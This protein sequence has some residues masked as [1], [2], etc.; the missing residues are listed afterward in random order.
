MT[1]TFVASIQVTLVAAAP[2]NVASAALVRHLDGAIVLDRIDGIDDLPRGLGDEQAPG[3]YRLRRRDDL[4]GRHLFELFPNDP[5]D[6]NNVP[7][8]M[9]RA[10]FERVLATAQPDHLALIPYKVPMHVGGEVRVVDR[11]WSATQTR[12]SSASVKPE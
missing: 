11:V 5:D 8:R 12:N 7:A 4:L 1:D 2:P 9:L 6:P 10:S 3:R